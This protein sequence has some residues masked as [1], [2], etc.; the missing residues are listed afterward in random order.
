MVFYYHYHLP[1]KLHRDTFPLPAGRAMARL[2][3]KTRSTSGGVGPIT[4]SKPHTTPRGI[5][6]RHWWQL[7]TPWRLVGRRCPSTCKHTC[8]CPN[9]SWY[10]WGRGTSIHPQQ[11]SKETKKKWGGGWGLM[12]PRGQWPLRCVGVVCAC[13]CMRASEY[14]RACVYLCA[15]VYSCMWFQA[16]E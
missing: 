3:Q 16:E 12:M 1:I 6:T 4:R 8:C 7:P 14:V 2:A 11:S 15:R 5:G 13:A 9:W 10:R